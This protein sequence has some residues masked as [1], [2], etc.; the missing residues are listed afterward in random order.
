MPGVNDLVLTAR[1]WGTYPYHAQLA[2][3]DA[4]S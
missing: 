1:G 4:L 3:R 2:W